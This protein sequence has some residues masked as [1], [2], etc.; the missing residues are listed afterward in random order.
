MKIFG[1]EYCYFRRQILPFKTP[2]M[3]HKYLKIIRLNIFIVRYTGI[4]FAFKWL[5]LKNILKN[6]R[7][8]KPDDL[9]YI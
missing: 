4:Y 7:Y 3:P 2:I 1:V 5:K 8:K 9:K 6:R